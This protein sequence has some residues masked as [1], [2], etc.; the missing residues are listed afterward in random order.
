[1]ADIYSFNAGVYDA[2]KYGS[3]A[4]LS[5]SLSGTSNQIV[6]SASNTNTTGTL[7]GSDVV[8]VLFDEQPT[9]ALGPLSSITLYSPD[10]GSLGP[11]AD[12]VIQCRLSAGATIAV[13]NTD[14]YTALYTI[15]VGGTDG[16]ITLSQEG[17]HVIGPEI[18][19]KVVLGLL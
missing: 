4:P 3:P 12:T 10:R 13:T 7:N 2:S 14:R 17:H 1:M 8:G 6:L 11:I 16:S 5:Y 18:R 9:T 15:P 19:R